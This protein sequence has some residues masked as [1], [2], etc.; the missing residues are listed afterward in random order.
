MLTLFDL[1]PLVATIGVAAFSKAARDLLIATFR[2]PTRTTVVLT[3][4]DGTNVA[5]EMD[6]QRG[7]LSPE[8]LAALVA[9]VEADANSARA[10]S[11]GEGRRQTDDRP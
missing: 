1:I 10:T 9:K 7:D 5:V 8:Q 4:S 2:R 6:K 3:K 11:R